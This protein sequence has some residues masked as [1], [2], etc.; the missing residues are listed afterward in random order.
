MST[1][2]ASFTAEYYEANKNRDV[3]EH[4]AQVK[5]WVAEHRTVVPEPESI[6][7]TDIEVSGDAFKGEFTLASDGGSG[8]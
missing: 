5:A 6:T 1:D 8:S 2:D 4:I 7:L 3:D